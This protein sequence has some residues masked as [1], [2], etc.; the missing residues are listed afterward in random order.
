[1]GKEL[2]GGG[3]G[4]SQG[5]RLWTSRYTLLLTRLLIW[6]LPNTN[7]VFFPELVL[8]VLRCNRNVLLKCGGGNHRT[9]TVS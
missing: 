6:Y 3:L 9:Q 1:M 7:L 8:R 4:I 2:Q 5:I